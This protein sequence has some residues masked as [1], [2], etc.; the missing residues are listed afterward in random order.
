MSRKV[1]ITGSSRGV[2]YSI[3]QKFIENNWNICVTGKSLENLEIA[4]QNLNSTTSNNLFEKIDFRVK[5]EVNI[6]KEKISKHWGEIN[7][8]VVNI[9]SGS[10]T[11]SLNSSFSE[12]IDIFKINFV[13]AYNSIS[14]LKDLII[15]SR[16]NSIILVGSIAANSN[17]GAPINYAASKKALENLSNF[18]SITLSE[19]GVKVNCVHLGHVYVKDGVWEKKDK[20]KPG[21]FAK[22]VKEKTLI[23]RILDPNEVA[24]FIYALN[25]SQYKN[26][27]TGS[28]FII[29]GGTSKLKI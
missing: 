8:L 13:T 19:F 3:A 1:L 26:A 11:K 4:R 27:I 16:D 12:N 10:G 9:G 22:F 18:F 14:I 7:S 23:K 29:D 25:D 6:L 21:D 28:S 17:V 5:S 2:G 20:E 15:K 24:S